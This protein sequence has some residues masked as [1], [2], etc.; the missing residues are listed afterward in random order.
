VTQ[1]PGTAHAATYAS[2]IVELL[3][4]VGHVDGLFHVHEQAFVQRYIESVLLQ[5]EESAPASERVSL[6]AA[7][8]THFH[9]LYQRL[10]REVAGL[11]DQAGAAWQQGRVPSAL[12]SR[13]MALFSALPAQEQKT[14]LELVHALIHADRVLTP[15]EQQLYHDLTSHFSAE[16]SGGA[17]P[18][19]VRMQALVDEP[20]AAQA[21]APLVVKAP[22]QRELVA[23][24]HSLI[25]P[26]ERTYSPHPIE[27]KSQIDWDFQLIQ[28]AANQWQR[29]RTAGAGRLAGVADATQVPAGARF[30]DG[31][32]YAFKPTRPT[33]LVV[34]GDLHGCYSCLKA[35]L[36]QSNFIQRVWAHQWDP[37]RYPDIKLVLLGDYIDRGRYSFDGV[38][39]A[40]L[41]LFL[42][43]PDNVF[44]LRG[45]HEY[46]RWYQNRVVSGVYPAEALA[47]IAPH[48][49]G[50]ML[51]AYRLMFEQMPTSLLV[52]QLLFVHGG[53]PRDDTFEARYRDLSSLNDSE[54][55]FQMLWSDPVPGQF[56]P[57]E[58][59]RQNPRFSFGYN[60]FG[61]FMDRLKLNTMIRGHEQINQGFHVVYKM[62]EQQL[63]TLFS[64]GG[65]DNSDLPA[66]SS[67]RGV[68]PMA[69]T[70][71]VG[72]DAPTATP[73]PLQ[74][75]PFN[76]PPHNGLYRP[77]PLLE[78][79]YV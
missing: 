62:G 71:E 53:I 43:M 79:R 6:R 70:I 72:N 20:P 22:V 14:S 25:D 58:L 19:T 1:D 65:K 38:L 37:Q 61:A 60:Q 39:R 9:E 57:V 41:Y 33:E 78:F 8:Q 27:R 28:Q 63:L 26:L 11:A 75:Q 3:L 7:W 30:L 52:D 51:E 45:N 59:Q 13:A 44:V 47:S 5:V 49:P 42:S 29:Q 4:T 24:S 32:V 12:R 35:A 69:L 18:V 15:P 74:Y 10:D 56:I 21:T 17:G 76:Y 73:W 46:F 36:L 16:A 31:H 77:H 66:E 50:E 55:R 40:V 23:L 54:L 2:S 34:L 64:A 48:V 68:T 67:Y